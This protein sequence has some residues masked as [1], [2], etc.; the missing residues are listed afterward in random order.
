M[1]K[2]I[3]LVA[4]DGSKRPVAVSKYQINYNNG[5]G[6]SIEFGTAWNHEEILLRALNHSNDTGIGVSLL[7]RPFAANTVYIKPL[8]LAQDD[9]LL[10]KEVARAS[11][12]P[13]VF[14]V[15]IAGDLTPIA[16]S[17]IIAIY[18][19]GMAV[20]INIPTT[21]F[22]LLAIEEVGIEAQVLA[23]GDAK[24]EKLVR[25]TL[26]L[27]AANL[28]S[29]KPAVWEPKFACHTGRCNFD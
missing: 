11:E 14:A 13:Q 8:G 29:L 20:T 7:A 6:F 1:E 21:K 4:A 3:I 2:Q 25:L 15:G 23:V 18:E 26:E 10:V 17:Q 27:Q 22:P 16:I 19:N 5:T 28:L 9:A 24:S 12:L